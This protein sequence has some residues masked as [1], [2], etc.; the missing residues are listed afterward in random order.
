M[1]NYKRILSL[2]LAFVLVLSNIPAVS[3]FAAEE[4]TAKATVTAEKLGVNKGSATMNLSELGTTDWMHLDLQINRKAKSTEPAVQNMVA[5]YFGGWG[6]GNKNDAMYRYQVVTAQESGSATIYAALASFDRG[7][8]V[9]AKLYKITD[10]STTPN[11]SNTELVAEKTI[12]GA[13]LSGMT[14]VFTD[15]ELVKDQNYAV[16]LGCATEVT[17]DKAKF[18]KGS[19]DKS[20]GGK[21]KADGSWATDVACGI[22]VD[23]GRESVGILGFELLG[24]A[25]WNES[26]GDCAVG[27]TYNDGTIVESR[28]N[29]TR[30]AN[31]GYQVGSAESVGVAIE[32]V[33]G[34][35]IT[36]PADNSIQTLKFVTTTWQGE[37]AVE[38]Y[39][40]GELVE[41]Y[42]VTK[43]DYTND[44]Y[45]AVYTVVAQPNVK[46]EAVVRYTQ[47]NH[48]HGNISAS[49]VTLSREAVPES[50]KVV[51]AIAALPTEITL[52]DEA[53]IAA[54]RS[55]Y[56]ALSDGQKAEVTNLDVLTAAETKL[57]ELKA[58]A[59]AVADKA[60]AD[61][62]IAKITAIGE[63]T[64]D[65]EAAITE[66]RAAYTAL[67]DAQ[68][69]LVEN[70]KVLEAAEAALEELKTVDPDQDM[71]SV[72]VTDPAGSMNLTE[73][74]NADW[75]HFNGDGKSCFEIRKVDANIIKFEE[76]GEAVMSTAMS[77]SKV[78]YSW[79]DGTPNET[80]SDTQGGVINYT[81][82]TKDAVVPAGNGWKISVPEYDGIQTLT[83]VSGVWE[84]S[85]KISIIAGGKVV[86]ENNELTA[87][88]SAIQKI[89]T[90]TVSPNVAIE[91]I[92]E[93]TGE[94]HSYG[95]SSL[96]GISLNRVEVP[97]MVSVEVTDPAGSMNLTEMGNADWLH[98]NGD[99][100]SC[101]PIRKA[102]ADELAAYNAWVQQYG[103]NIIDYMSTSGTSG[104]TFGQTADQVWRF[105]TFTPKVS[106]ELTS[107]EV[108]LIKKGSPST[109]IA[110]LF[111]VTD[112]ST[113]AVEELGTTTV[114]AENITSNAVLA[115]DFGDI[116]VEAGT[117]Y[118]VALTQ[119]TLDNSN[120][121]HWCK[122]NNPFPN[123]KIKDVACTQIVQENTAAALR[124]VIGNPPA[125]P[126]VETPV[127][128]IQFEN[129]GEA[130]MSTAMSDSKVPY[131]WTD[132]TP[133][134]NGSDTKGGV[135]NYNHGTLDSAVPAG[136]GWKL[137]IP[138]DDSVQTLTFV[139]G[140]WQ[141]SGKISILVDGDVVYENNELTAGG[142]AIQKVYTVTV[143]PNV[144]IEVRYEITAE[145]NKHGNSSLGGISLNRVKAEGGDDYVSLLADAVEAADLWLNLDGISAE[146]KTALAE[147]KAA[148]EASLAK[149]NKLTAT[150]A[151]I[152]YLTL[153]NAIKNA[154][155]SFAAGNFASSYAS[156][157]VSSFGWEGDKHAPIA[158]IDGSYKLRDNGNAYV[159]F[160]VGNPGANSIS[161][162]NAE[163]YLP[164]FISEY[165]KD[166]LDIKIENFADE[167][168][169]NGN[170]YEVVYSRMSVKNNGENNAL[171]PVVSDSLVAL[172]DAAKTAE[173][174]AP[175]EIVVR[176]Y[177]IGADRFGGAYAYPSAEELAAAGSFDDHYDHMKTY[178]NNRL[179][180]II[181]I[182]SIPEEYDVLIDAYKAGY[183]YM[184]IIA[185]GYELHVGEN[186][187]DRVFDHDVIGMLASLIESGHT[188]HFADYAQYILQN[189][190]YPDARWKYSWPFALYLQKTGDFT[191]IVNHWSQLKSNAH[192]IADCREVCQQAG[193]GSVVTKSGETAR[194]MKR[195]DAID[196]FGYWTIDN[197]AGMF[198]LTTYAYICDQLY[199]EYGTEEYKT[200]AEWAK[201]EYKSLMESTE[202]VL[203]KTKTD[204]GFD[205]IPIS[206]VVPNELSAR[207]NVQDGNWAAHYL[208]GRWDWDGYLFGADQDSWM[209]EDV[210]KTYTYI[211][212]AK[213]TV[214][215]SIYNMGGYPHGYFSSAY[216]AGYYSAALSGEAYRDGGIEA[217][218][219]MIEN[220]QGGPF[221]WWEGVAYPNEAN[222][223]WNI[224]S[225]NGGGGSCQHMWGQS[226]AT[227]VLIDA[228]LAEKADGTVIVGR[229]L[230]LE[231]NAEGEQITVSNYLANGGKRIGFDMTTSNGVITFKLTGDKL[232]NPVSLELLALKNNIASVSNEA[233][234]V[235]VENGTVLIPAGVTEIT[236]TL[237][238]APDEII[239]LGKATDAVN[240][241]LAAAKAVD[242]DDYVTPSVNALEEA[243]AAANAA[244]E[245]KDIE[246]MY[247][248]VEAIEEAIDGLVEVQ[249]F[250]VFYD[251]IT[252]MSD[253]GHYSFG[254]QVDER[255]RYVTFKTGAEDITF[256]KMIVDL[257][258]DA[259]IED[260]AL[261]S[262]YTLGEDNKT[263]G[264][265]LATMRFSPKDV[266][267]DTEMLELE[268]SLTLK[269]DTY[270]AMHFAMDHSNGKYGSW[271][272][273]TTTDVNMDGLYHIKIQ[274]NGNVVDESFLGVVKMQMITALTDK[275]EL[276]AA[277]AA[278][279]EN[280]ETLGAAIEVLL[281][282]E[283]TQE[284][285]DDALAALNAEIPVVNVQNMIDA[286]GEVTL[287]SEA[288]IVSARKAY[289]ALSDEQKALVSNVDALT[290]AE[291]KLAQLKEEAAQAAADKAAADA[292][293]SK[294]EAIGE[295][296]L[297]SEEAIKEA[298]AA[299]DA[300]TDAQKA[301]V[302]AETLKALTDAEAKLAELKEEAQK[303]EDPKPSDPTDPT[304]PEEKPSDPT[305]PSEPEEEK[306][307]KPE[308]EK[309]ED[310]PTEPSEPEKA[311]NPFEDITEDMFCY[312]AVLWAVEN[313]I[314]TG[315]TETTFQPSGDC[316]RAQVVTFLWRAAGEPEPKNAD[317]SFPDVAEGKYYTKA[318]AWAVENGITNG[319]KD[320][321]FGPNKTCTRGQ[322]V[323]FLWRYAGEP[324]AKEETA[325]PDVDLKSYCGDAV[326]WAVEEGI[327]TGY[328]NGTFG[329]DKT[330]KRD[331]IV[332]FLY[333]YLAE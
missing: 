121:Y 81:Q 148:G 80:G 292:A 229:G 122:A 118:A 269:A 186:G 289:D 216:N 137:S 271:T 190:Q 90:V 84:S 6:F 329:P 7:Y 210:D 233:C 323:T 309:P 123:G 63:V 316:T 109:L 258:S 278:A 45:A 321:T 310:K 313:K 47:K 302:D 322:I 153:S 61:A 172:N 307:S 306:P 228:F 253:K 56:D 199:A 8:D 237:S 290:A 222:N 13:N 82:G 144:A 168:I 284:E 158:Y 28:N 92:Y 202:A 23:Y 207:A 262:I 197:Y 241:A 129:I 73:M 270:Y 115:L 25:V 60:A 16:A 38:V 59:Q 208:F 76:I 3:V 39:A 4:E 112:P 272:F 116:T 254:E 42:A 286:I 200:E 320:G 169:I 171:L 141:S 285:I 185:D 161:W 103:D 227:K 93:I 27:Y 298:R 180:G 130:A 281:D 57:A 40:D 256:D 184:L 249:T 68:K 235:D 36:V 293:A 294:I 110:K 187:Y 239:E 98:F 246:A 54:A 69:A 218:M 48:Q 94:T 2:L 267:N 330:C 132:G 26:F 224:N 114:A 126:T 303:P 206:M 162:Y 251:T 308:D 231:F 314:T 134:L 248:A 44:K 178:W 37:F 11:A 276:D 113:F 119:Q 188:E 195:T 177:C 140:V 176:D 196:S 166:T 31:I 191:T 51:E 128:I 234:V 143:S 41:S 14:P 102:D 173:F 164:C 104:R 133:I 174:V 327:T 167:V 33:N 10:N 46:V 96:G 273:Y 24:D 75:L 225:S 125:A 226:T 34:Y 318:V 301:L 32:G 149:G 146:S 87:G 250:N 155:A 260:D 165:A 261:I 159:T 265:A 181:D 300:L 67:T 72:T 296:K 88:G 220:A 326:L 211:M 127:G 163:G 223:P 268:E 117:Y 242:T 244:I 252:G 275:T 79:T 53:A 108:A 209:H 255:I 89:Y 324:E 29:L 205:Y 18:A 15:V 151:Y 232:E 66:A 9:A 85:G 111:K 101:F 325:F 283:T 49:G 150:E 280:C 135:I 71:V 194:I 99:S 315:K 131:S 182:E 274:G 245:A 193:Y 106:G 35:K 160:G 243:V 312:D 201:A 328:K 179:D 77:D 212:N 221:G 70:I 236:I 30:G 74:G 311:E 183:I 277:V 319:F 333:R 156:G 154:K 97:K 170:R 192:N 58:A 95:N 203:E 215:D 198:G 64:L 52:E 214:F 288:D 65:S 1:K 291:A 287:D 91:V 43:A 305:D 266:T 22:I 259:S 317:I 219:W 50:S 299:Y 12:P 257:S 175:G 136:N 230:P 204:Y 240:S 297:E 20:L 139:S 147:A 332:T 189:V 105:Q 282:T 5:D 120:I 157:M 263:L 107:V 264:E 124:V 17:G 86:Y 142:S 247:A 83:F 152:N 279:P 238:D 100:N 304:D 19:A 78:S 217:Y 138:A 213:S 55:A 145:T 331:Q 295:V 21:I 62:V